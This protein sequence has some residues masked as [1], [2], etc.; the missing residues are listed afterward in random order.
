MTTTINFAKSGGLVPAIAQDAVSGAVLMLA[1][2]NEESY[3]ETLKTGRSLSTSAEAGTSCGGRVK[4][5]AM[6]NL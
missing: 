6:S 1:W 5:V 2:M 3:Q 4:R